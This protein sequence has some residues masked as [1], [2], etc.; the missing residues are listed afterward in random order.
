SRLG[1]A[2]ASVAASL[3]AA[4]WVA[5]VCGGAEVAAIV[6]A[7][8]TLFAGSGA[9]AV[10]VSV[11]AVAVGTDGA[12]DAMGAAAATGTV[13]A[14]CAL[15]GSASRRDALGPPNCQYKVKPIAAT[16]AAIAASGHQRA[17]TRG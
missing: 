7:S 1:S 4:S 11:S 6:A 16:P 2:V 13:A 3:D 5:P 14:A 10:A 17:A 15:G 12:G 8:P 9:A